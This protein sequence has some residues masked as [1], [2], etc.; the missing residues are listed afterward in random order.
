MGP[1]SCTLVVHQTAKTYPQHK[2]LGR[3]VHLGGAE[4]DPRDGTVW[5]DAQG[6]DGEVLKE[7]YW[8]GG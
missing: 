3:V 1:N 5:R 2:Q 7:V 4:D 6:A 8:Q